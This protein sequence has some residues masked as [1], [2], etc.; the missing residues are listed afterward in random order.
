ML[1]SARA[2]DLPG[3]AFRKN[4]AVIE[5]V[6]RQA[7][8]RGLICLRIQD[9]FLCNRQIGFVDWP[10]T[11]RRDGCCKVCIRGGPC[12]EKTQAIKCRVS[13]ASLDDQVVI[14]CRRIPKGCEVS[15]Y[16]SLWRSCAAPSLVLVAG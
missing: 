1:E 8:V 3:T 15:R 5:Q 12:P 4:S 11:S 2:R 6:E 9:S 14:R 16:P 7:L 10:P 13:R